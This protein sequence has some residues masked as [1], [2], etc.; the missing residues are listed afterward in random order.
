MQTMPA[1]RTG[2][3]TAKDAGE[4]APAPISSDHRRVRRCFLSLDNAPPGV[5]SPATARSITT[6]TTATTARSCEEATNIA[7]P[8]DHRLR[9]AMP[10]PASSSL[11]A[12]T[13]SE[14]GIRSQRRRG[15]NPVTVAAYSG[16]EVILD[17]GNTFYAEVV[18]HPQYIILDGSFLTD[19]CRQQRRSLTAE[20]WREPCPIQ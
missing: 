12:R 3:A 10:P 6:A 2:S 7:T 8:N 9:H 14:E 4:A 1:P 20:Q 11:S 17:P 18:P 15:K 16:E 5:M 19:P 13:Y